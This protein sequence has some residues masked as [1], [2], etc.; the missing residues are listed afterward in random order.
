M[1]SLGT[2]TPQKSL[3]DP[4]AD[5]EDFEPRKDAE[6]SSMNS[7]RYDIWYYLPIIVGRIIIDCDIMQ[8]HLKT[9]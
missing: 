9:P 5:D 6:N 2:T 7:R 1:K 8:I 3:I 4:L